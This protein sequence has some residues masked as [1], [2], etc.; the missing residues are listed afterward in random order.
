[1]LVCVFICIVSWCLHISLSFVC[2][3]VV[4]MVYKLH[5]VCYCTQDFQVGFNMYVNRMLCD[6]AFK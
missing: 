5:L 3:L 6:I 1:M 2:I 4:I